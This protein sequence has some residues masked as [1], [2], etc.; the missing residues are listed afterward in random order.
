M[1]GILVLR[2]DAIRIAVDQGHHRLP[3]GG[4]RALGKVEIGNE[5]IDRR[6]HFSSLDIEGS[7]IARS[8]RLLVVGVCR[9]RLSARDVKALDTNAAAGGQ[10]QAPLVLIE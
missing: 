9:F 7:S 1:W 3:L 4:K 8:N 5:T 2:V 6:A 10:L